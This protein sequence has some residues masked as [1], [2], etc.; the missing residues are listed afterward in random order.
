MTE[1]FHLTQHALHRIRSDERT[2][3]FEDE[4]L[5]ILESELYVIERESPHAI[6]LLFYSPEDRAWYVL[7]QSKSNKVIKTILS[8]HMYRRSVSEEKLKR[9]KSMMELTVRVTAEMKRVTGTRAGGTYEVGIGLVT[10]HTRAKNL[11]AWASH[12][13]SQAELQNL[14]NPYLSRKIVCVG[15]RLRTTKSRNVKTEV[16]IPWS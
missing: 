6:N 1:G 10:S 15:L 5:E 7:I 9:A 4:V 8:L 3:L 12:P 11:E 2:V 16:K 14:L 13:H